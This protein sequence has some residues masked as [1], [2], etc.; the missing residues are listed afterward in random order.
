MSLPPADREAALMKAATANVQLLVKHIFEL[1]I[2]KSPEV[3]PVVGMGI[4]HRSVCELMLHSAGTAAGTN[5][6]AAAHQAGAH[7]A[8]RDALG[9]LCAGE[10]HCETQAG[11]DGVG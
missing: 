3:G 9:A 7:K 2:E 1:P 8:P 10:G 4:P 5:H 11:P 6:Q